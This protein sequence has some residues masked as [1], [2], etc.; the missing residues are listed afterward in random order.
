[1]EGIALYHHH[2]SPLCQKFGS[3]K[4]LLKN[5]MFHFFVDYIKNDAATIY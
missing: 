5:A 3:G 2:G 4:N 1:M